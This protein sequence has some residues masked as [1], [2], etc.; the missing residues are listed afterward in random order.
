MRELN[1]GYYAENMIK[2]GFKSKKYEFE[3][4][5]LSKYYRQYSKPE[6]V[7][8]QIKDF[9]MKH[10]P[11]FNEVKSMNMVNRVVR[12]AEVNSLFVVSPIHITKSELS[13][14]GE[15]GDLKLEKLAFVLLVISKINRQS[16][17]T[18]IQ[19][20]IAIVEK[21][22][23]EE[24]NKKKKEMPELHDGYYANGKINGFFKMAKIYLSKQ[25]RFSAIKKLIDSGL[26]S[27]TK[28]CKYKI[29]FV[30]VESEGLIVIEKFD[31]FVLEYMKYLG[32]NIGSCEVCGDLFEIKSN[33]HSYCKVCWKNKQLEKYNKYNKK[34]TSYHH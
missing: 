29:E 27:M 3:L 31:N 21:F 16:Y 19:D 5:I 22:N 23:A 32:D 33:R 11:K 28:N 2:S 18:F 34:R 9:C 13:T 17:E 25:E 8:Q 7:K 20:K 14:I 1:E 24:K 30:D 15:L 10:I 4:K 26:I 6:E 12:Y